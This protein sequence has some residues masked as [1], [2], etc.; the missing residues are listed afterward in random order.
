MAVVSNKKGDCLRREVQVMGWHSYFFAVVGAGDAAR[1]KPF[2]DPLHHALSHHDTLLPGPGIWFVGDSF[3][4]KECAENAQCTSIMIQDNIQDGF[5]LFHSCS[6][7]LSYLK[8]MFETK[9]L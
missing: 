9:D 8:Q 4:D 2:A 1:D 5:P 6:S 3:V 7:L